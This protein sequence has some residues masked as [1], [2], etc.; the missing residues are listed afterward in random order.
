MQNHQAVV[1][2]IKGSLSNNSHLVVIVALVFVA[3]VIMVEEVVAEDLFECGAK[4]R[5]VRFKWWKVVFLFT[6]I[7]DD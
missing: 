7:M 1:G 3:M 5:A 2:S 4:W 6:P